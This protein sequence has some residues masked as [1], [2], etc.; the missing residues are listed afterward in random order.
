M[1]TARLPNPLSEGL[2]KSLKAGRFPL[3]VAC[4]MSRVVPVMSPSPP[5]DQASGWSASTSRQNLLEEARA[6][7][8]KEELV[9][10]FDEG[11]AEQ[12]PYPDASF[13]NVVSMLGAMY[14]PRPDRAAAELIRVCR[15]GGRVIMVNWTSTGC[16]GQMIKLHEKFMPPTGIP[17]STL[18]GDEATVRER[19]RDGVAELLMA[20]RIYP[21]F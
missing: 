16:M 4:S 14:A 21:S 6:R 2:W 15:P 19:L 12:L 7:A 9:V 1:T 5:H 17:S 8:A 20:R 13:D 11:D 3:R 18:W 10:Q